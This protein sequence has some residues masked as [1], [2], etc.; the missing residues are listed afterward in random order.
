MRILRHPQVPPRRLR[1]HRS[2]LRRLRHQT[3]DAS[4]CATGWDPR[5]DA[6]PSRDRRWADGTL[7]VPDHGSASQLE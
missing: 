3:R 5:S 7:V 4:L 1:G 2:W 6:H